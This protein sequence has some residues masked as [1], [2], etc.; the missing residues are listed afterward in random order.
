MII[1]KEICMIYMQG[2]I[3]D[4]ILR[5]E[6]KECVC[7]MALNKSNVGH[8]CAPFLRISEERWVQLLFLQ[9]AQRFFITGS[10][11]I[12]KCTANGETSLNEWV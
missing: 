6:L 1:N 7:G 12:A 5:V 8:V 3:D 10:L 4:G 2:V 9:S 11:V